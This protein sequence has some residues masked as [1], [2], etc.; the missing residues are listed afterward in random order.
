MPPP[1]FAQDEQEPV[2]AQAK[3][4]DPALDGEIIVTAQKR[5]ER[6]ID[7]PMSITAASGDQL[8]KQ[9]ISD[10]AALTKL[11]PGFTYQ[12]SN[13]GTP[14]FTIRGVGYI[15]YSVTAGPT[16]TAYIDQVPLPY[17]VMTRGATL[18]LERVEVLKGPQG[19]LFGQNSTGGAVN[20]IAAK[21]TDELRA[22]VDLGYGSYNEV[23][24]GAFVSGPLTDTL[25]ARLAVRSEY[26]DGWQKSLT[27]PG[28]TLGRKRFYN[29]RLLVDWDPTDDVKFELNMSAWQDR[30]DMLASQL[31][32]VIPQNALNPR[33]AP[34]LALLSQSPIPDSLREADWDADKDFKRN[35]KFYLFSLRGDWTISENV[36]LTSLTSYSHATTRH[37]VDVDGSAFNNFSWLRQDGLLKSFNQELRL[38]GDAGPVKWMI[39]GNYQNQT[40]KEYQLLDSRGSQTTLDLSF[41][42]PVIGPAGRIYVWDLSAYYNNQRPISKSVFGSLEVA[43]SDQLTLRASGRYNKEKRRFNGC[44]ADAGEEQSAEFD[45]IRDAFALLSSVLSGSPTTIA[46][47]GCLTFNDAT[48]KPELVRRSLNEDNFSWRVGADWKPDRD[49]LIYATVSKGY[50]AGGFTILPSIFASQLDP[51]T[52]ESLLA[53]EAGVKLSLADRRLQLSG[54]GFYYDYSDKQLLG[55]AETAFG[56]LP[57]LINFPK[58][59]VKGFEVEATVLPVEG[60]RITGGVSHLVSR[61]KVDPSLAITPLGTPTTFVG[62]PFPN[63]PKWQA[64]G[65][66]EYSFPV[67]SDINLFLGGAVSHRSSSN[68]NFGELPQFTL[69][70]YT[71]VDLRG[72]AES[73]DGKWRLQAY[74]RNITNKW[75]WN[76]VFIT[77]DALAKA[78][79]IGATYGVSLSYRY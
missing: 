31:M 55:Y 63:T 22:G 27:R 34:Y 41:L 79:A 36:T 48:A 60:L 26:M 32:A 73:S 29:G 28:D 6:L 58:S 33:T 8:S 76:N 40:A 42:A 49:T 4:S 24:A 14:I 25:R 3:E 67:T 69:N 16:V 77:T 5:N 74:G 78:P 9:G 35:D 57:K 50:K 72:G 54:A 62:E 64:V 71:L 38:S 17:S 61:V 56:R 51:V 46:S 2:P 21:P 66:A 43:V 11:V 7:V 37:P 15:D 12:Q 1:A 53:Y 19:T 45:P 70:A 39:G 20:Y 30:S 44:L 23:I 59:S 65:D 75:Y 13:Y 52:Q 47:F 68:A 10:T 18:D